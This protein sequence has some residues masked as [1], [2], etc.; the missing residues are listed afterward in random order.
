MLATLA[1][2]T[3]GARVPDPCLRV[4]KLIQLTNTDWIIS[5][6]NN[7]V[8]S[9]NNEF[10]LVG[11]EDVLKRDFDPMRS[12]PAEQLGVVD[13]QVLAMDQEMIPGLLTVQQN[14]YFAWNELE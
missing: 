10:I 1:L 12:G 3:V 14:V 7:F 5:R 11:F 6:I 2:H 4:I 8:C 9:E 13:V